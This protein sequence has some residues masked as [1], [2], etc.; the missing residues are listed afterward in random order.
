M[1]A[2]R[3]PMIIVLLGPGR[4]GDSGDEPLRRK[5]RRRSVFAVRVALPIARG[6]QAAA[7]RGLPITV[8]ALPPAGV[9]ITPAALAFNYP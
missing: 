5:R 1:T 3:L 9:S 7:C 8:R 4:D 6:R 2:A